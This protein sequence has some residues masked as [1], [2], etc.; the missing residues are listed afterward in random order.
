LSG[1]YI[2]PGSAP[3]LWTIL[4]QIQIISK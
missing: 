4:T 2:E 1:T 3:S